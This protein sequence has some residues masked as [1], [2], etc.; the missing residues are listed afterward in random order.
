MVQCSGLLLLIFQTRR[1]ENTKYETREIESEALLN[2]CASINRS[3]QFAHFLHK[4]F[5]NYQLLCFCFAELWL[6]FVNF[7]SSPAR[8]LHACF[9]VLLLIP[10]K[11]ATERIFRPVDASTIWISCLRLG[12]ARLYAF[13]YVVC[14][15]ADTKTRFAIPDKKFACNAKNDCAVRPR[16]EFQP[17]L[18]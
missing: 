12:F 18:C 10:H 15:F 5:N 14:L 7:P 4:Q 17:M 3:S 8:S 6:L 16:L 9:V 2:E 1:Y 13:F 11:F